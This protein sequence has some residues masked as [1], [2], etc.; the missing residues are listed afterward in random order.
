[1]QCLKPTQTAAQQAISRLVNAYP[2]WVS[3]LVELEKWPSFVEKFSRLYEVDIS[4]AARQW[5]KKRGQCSSHLV[6]ALL[7]LDPAGREQVR[8]V[9][10]VTELGAG[11]VK[12]LEQLRDA[13][14]DRIVWGDYVLM[15]LTRPREWG[16][17][18]RWTWCMSPQIERQE[19]NYL[20][21]LAQ[22]CSMT[23]DASRLNAYT[24][25]LLRRPMHSGVRTQ[26]SRMLRRAMK[27][28]DKHS[29]GKT[30]P[31]P[32]PAKLPILDYSSASRFGS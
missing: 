16:G 29:M 24:S 5:R 4:P 18:S 17:G 15:Y 1:M 9:L 30:W 7:P 31:G 25:K 26:V 13:R 3:G 6:G 23:G 10:M 2:L 14:K 22:H 12:E 11:T 28:W 21:A 19:A 20:T 27:V 8:W 32:D